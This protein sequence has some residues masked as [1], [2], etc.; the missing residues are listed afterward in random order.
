MAAAFGFAPGG[1]WFPPLVETLI[2]AS[3]VYM[4]LENIVGGNPARRW[5]VAFVFGLVHGFGF[6]FAL[7]ETLQFAG[8][9][10]VTAL[11]AFNV[12]V[13]LGQVAV[14]LVLVPLANLLFRVVPERIGIIVL[15][16]LIAHT[17]WHWM[18]ERFA[19][20]RKFPLPPMDAAAMASLLRW[21]MGAIA[22]AVAVW[23]VNGW[24]TRK[25]DPGPSPR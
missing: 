19:E 15:S 5:I 8:S 24:V 12:G 9:H 10:L 18:T 17:G 23:L 3:I 6:A 22:I 14:L 13:E 4:A 16:A 2:A 21:A 7:R 25:L 20:L 1:L 11:L